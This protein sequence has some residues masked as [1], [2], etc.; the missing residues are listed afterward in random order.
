M[1]SFLDLPND[2]REAAQVLP[3]EHLNDWLRNSDYDSL[4][5]VV[6]T[7][8]RSGEALSFFN[9]S[10]WDFTP[11]AHHFAARKPHYQIEISVCPGLLVHDVLRYELMA[12]FYQW[13][14]KPSAQQANK[15]ISSSTLCIRA[16]S[17]LS[18][19]AP[20]ILQEGYESITALSDSQVFSN[21]NNYLKSKK[22][23]VGT[24]RNV[25]SAVSSIQTVSRWMH[26]EFSLPSFERNKLADQLGNQLRKQC[27]QTAAIPKRISDALYAEAIE[28]VET[29]WPYRELITRVDKELQK[30]YEEGAIKARLCVAEGKFQASNAFTKNGSVK[31]NVAFRKSLE[32]PKKIIQKYFGGN[33]V[34]DE[35]KT[36]K[37]FTRLLTRLRFE[38]YICIGGF[39]GM[40]KSEIYEINRDSFFKTIF[41]GFTFLFV[42]SRLIKFVDGMPRNELW[43]ASPIVEPAIDLIFAITEVYRAALSRCF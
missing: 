17:I 13:M 30:T 23:S 22:L 8:K 41:M 37:D 24:V 2:I 42:K 32:K 14:H 33:T 16:R 27:W 3:E 38:T 1:T 7:R 35:I 10:V 12:A 19:V 29:Y 26:Y 21:F 20:F 39:T 4:S 43:V 40:R 9:D 15:L 25:L 6:V 11:Y 34:F 28:Q 36:Y 18:H 31:A 5:S